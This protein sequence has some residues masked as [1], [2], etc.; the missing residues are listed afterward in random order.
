MGAFNF[1]FY[2]EGELLT[3]DCSKAHLLLLT[4]EHECCHRRCNGSTI[5]SWGPVLAIRC[6]VVLEVDDAQTE[7]DCQS[8]CPSVGA[9]HA[10]PLEARPAWFGPC[11]PDSCQIYCPEGKIGQ[12]TSKWLQGEGL[13]DGAR[14]RGQGC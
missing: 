8:G 14:I 1:S 9:E 4:A 11:A 12:I 5:V 10:P 13:L 2:W 3:S 6:L 7:A